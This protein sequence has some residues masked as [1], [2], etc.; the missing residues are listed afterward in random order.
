MITGGSE[1]VRRPGHS[2]SARPDR[3]S[4]L[5]RDPLSHQRGPSLSGKKIDRNPTLYVPP[6]VTISHKVTERP[7]VFTAAWGGTIKIHKTRLFLVDPAEYLP[8]K[9]TQL[10]RY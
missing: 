9:V 6:D 8:L 3:T 5:T 2:D 4:L 1:R 7:H 10:H